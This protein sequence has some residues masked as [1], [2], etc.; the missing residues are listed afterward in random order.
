[1]KHSNKIMKKRSNVEPV[2]QVCAQFS[3]TLRGQCCERVR[4]AIAQCMP[5][6]QAADKVE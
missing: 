1:M 5:L 4:A 6:V 2:E 3:R